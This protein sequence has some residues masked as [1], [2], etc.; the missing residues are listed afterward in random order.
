[1]LLF[2]LL[3]AD[4]FEINTVTSYN[5]DYDAKPLEYVNQIIFKH[6]TEIFYFLIE[7]EELVKPQIYTKSI[8]NTKSRKLNA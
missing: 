3:Q 7:C 2:I 1:M 8:T 4:R 5:E 6:F